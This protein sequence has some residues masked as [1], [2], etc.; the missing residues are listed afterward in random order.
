MSNRIYTVLIVPERSSKVRRLRIPHRRLMQIFVIILS[1]AAVIGYMGVNYLHVVDEAGHN[2]DLKE[3]NIHLKERLR[4]V[5]EELAR[6][7]STLQRIDKFSDKLRTITRLNDPE[8]N[9]AYVGLPQAGRARIPVQ[10]YE[11][12]IDDDPRTHAFR[13][14]GAQPVHCRMAT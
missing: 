1:F 5:Q 7:D 13:S 9:L 3:D 14:S 6:I 2:R 4:I 10:R 12:L 8:R 11:T